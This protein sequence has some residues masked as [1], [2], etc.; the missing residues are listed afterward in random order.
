LSTCNVLL[1]DSIASTVRFIVK[2]L[3]DQDKWNRSEDVASSFLRAPA[4]TEGG[5]DLGCT[6]ITVGSVDYHIHGIVHGASLVSRPSKRVRRFIRDRARHYAGPIGLNLLCEER[7]SRYWGLDQNT[8]IDDIANT[9]SASDQSR[10][11]LDE[12]RTWRGDI[13]PGS[14]ETRRRL[15]GIVRGAIDQALRDEHW[16]GVVRALYA[17]LPYPLILDDTP[18]DLAGF[19]TD[20]LR[21]KYM[22]EYMVSYADL[23]GIS[24]LHSLVGLGHEREV[25]YFIENPNET[26]SDC[27]ISLGAGA[28]LRRD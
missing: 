8:D 10:Q 11:V 14:S 20:L 15:S 23:S 4:L 25:G 28:D 9:D 22:A 18:D 17:E 19:Y 26:L 21:S 13:A 2:H 3:N 1:E 27:I 12:W 24:N 6:T 7:F 5:A 16:I